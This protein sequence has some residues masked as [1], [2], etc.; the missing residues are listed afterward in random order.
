MA[1]ALE[2]AHKALHAMFKPDETAEGRA[3]AIARRDNPAADQ[4]AQSIVI[5]SLHRPGAPGVEAA[6]A[7]GPKDSGE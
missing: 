5:H 3:V 7:A 6:S 4:N 1:R 2:V